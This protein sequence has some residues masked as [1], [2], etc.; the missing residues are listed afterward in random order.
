MHGL[1]YGLE[2]ELECERR[3]RVINVSVKEGGR[4]PLLKRERVI[5]ALNVGGLGAS[6]PCPSIWRT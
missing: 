5:V 4:R 2:D 6:C 1:Q 3:R